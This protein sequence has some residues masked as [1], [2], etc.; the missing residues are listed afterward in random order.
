MTMLE[1]NKIDR[2]LA[3]FWS[4]FH[5]D[6]F[7]HVAVKVWTQ[8]QKAYNKKKHRIHQIND[9]QQRKLRNAYEYEERQR[10][11]AALVRVSKPK[12][13]NPTPYSERRS[14]YYRIREALLIFPS[15]CWVCKRVA[16][17]RHHLILLSQGGINE[18]YNLVPLCKKCHA[19]IH[20]W[21]PS[22]PDKEQNQEF[23][24]QEE[25]LRDIMFLH[26]TE[27]EGLRNRASSSKKINHGGAMPGQ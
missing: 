10:R 25:H 26:T 19:Y 7:P 6:D 17:Y 4:S 21:L 5:E 22:E 8:T 11:Y 9:R 16:K 27:L 1:F 24:E 3:F 15:D 23:T 14:E 2:T 20:P 12:F 18:P 13:Y